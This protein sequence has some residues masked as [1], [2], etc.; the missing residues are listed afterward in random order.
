MTC[1]VLP[2]YLDTNY[3]GKAAYALATLQRADFV[4]VHVEAPDEAGHNGDSQAKV[5]AIEDFDARVVGPILA[6]LSVNGAASG[7]AHPRS[8]HAHCAAHPQPRASA[9]CAVG[10]RG[11][12]PI[13]MQT[14]GERAA[15]WG[16]MQVEHGHVLMDYLT[17]RCR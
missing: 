12:R 17:G 13:A 6:G 3:E 10:G 8:P 1:P 9:L 15:E 2:G 4:Y 5:Q 16:S 7:A 11:L 14:Y